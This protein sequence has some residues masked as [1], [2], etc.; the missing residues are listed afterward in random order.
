MEQQ[1]FSYKDIVI[2]QL[3]FRIADLETFIKRLLEENENLKRELSRVSSEKVTN[4][5][6]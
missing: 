6:E 2:E 5:N 3:S 1:R 4:E